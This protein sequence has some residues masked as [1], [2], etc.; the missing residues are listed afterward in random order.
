MRARSNSA[1]RSADA[2]TPMR[3]RRT[4]SDGAVFSALR[5]ASSESRNF[6]SENSRSASWSWISDDCE[7]G[8]A[9]AR[10]T[11]EAAATRADAAATRKAICI[12]PPGVIRATF[13]KNRAVVKPRAGGDS[14]RFPA[15][16]EAKNVSARVLFDRDPVVHLVNPQNLRVAAVAT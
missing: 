13:Y 11:N 15:F 6:P 5:Y 14:R 4:P 1:T 3:G 2:I 12:V 8:A 9:S 10:S 7:G 16:R